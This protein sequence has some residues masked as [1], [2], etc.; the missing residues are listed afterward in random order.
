MVGCGLGGGIGRVRLIGRVFAEQPFGAEAAEHF[1]SGD[2]V[3]AERRLRRRIQRAPVA[4]R[5]LKKNVGAVDIGGDERAGSS[6]ERSTWDSA[7]RC[8]TRSG[9][10][11]SSAA[12]TPSA[13]QMSP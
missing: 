12:R 5:F 2:V 7:A 10:K 13:S 3:E 6:M 1:V 9:L 11:L 4:Q 8:I